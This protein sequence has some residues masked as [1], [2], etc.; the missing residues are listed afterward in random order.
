[1]AGVYFQP[2]SPRWLMGRGRTDEARAVLARVVEPS[3]VEG[4]LAQIRAV[5]DG[6]ARPTVSAVLGDKRLRRVL[7]GGV[8]VA[9]LQQIIGI[10]TI[11]YY[12]PSILTALGFADSVALIANAGLGA[13]TVIVT[14]IMLFVVDKVGRRLPLIC[15]AIA[16]AVAMAVLG[17]VFS[18]A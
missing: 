11:V 1:V 13:L 12:A 10:N 6:P 5:L 14:V 8:G 9:F 2:E 7:L 3:E 15:G 4:E 18:V 16:M 17:T